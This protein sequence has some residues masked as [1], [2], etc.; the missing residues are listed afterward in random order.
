MPN[1]ARNE[2]GQHR[3]TD[4]DEKEAE[5]LAQWTGISIDLAKELVKIWGRDRQTLLKAAK[6]FQ[7][8][9]K[10]TANR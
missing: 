2:R 10:G 4:E 8:S 3:L 9:R 1:K 5:L 6:A 7:S